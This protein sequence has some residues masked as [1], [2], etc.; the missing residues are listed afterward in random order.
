LADKL[1]VIEADCNS[2][3]PPAQRADAIAPL[4]HEI[5]QFVRLDVALLDCAA[6]AVHDAE[7]PPPAL[8]QVTVKEATA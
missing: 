4:E 8:L 6:D 1:K 5:D 3:C 7:T 2:I